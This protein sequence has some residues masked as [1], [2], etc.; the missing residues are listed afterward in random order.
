MSDEPDEPTNG[1]DA[2]R[3]DDQRWERAGLPKCKHCAMAM[4]DT[5]TREESDVSPGYCQRAKCERAGLLDAHLTL[6]EAECATNRACLNDSHHGH[7]EVNAD[8]IDLVKAAAE[9]L[10][11]VRFE[12]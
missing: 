9:Q 12:E 11:C 10:R 2:A 6:V 7:C 8:D 4:I 5:T 1:R 3:R